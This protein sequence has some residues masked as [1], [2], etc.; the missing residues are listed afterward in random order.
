VSDP[1][2]RIHGIIFVNS[3]VHCGAPAIRNLKDSVTT[4][5]IQASMHPYSPSKKGSTKHKKYKISFFVSFGF[6]LFLY[7]AFGAKIEVCD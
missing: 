3:V 6:L 4:A 7:I 5:A 1:D 2:L